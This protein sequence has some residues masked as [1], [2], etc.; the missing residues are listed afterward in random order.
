MMYLLSH[1]D[2]LTSPRRF[3]CFQAPPCFGGVFC[4]PV[5]CE[6]ISWGPGVVGCGRLRCDRV[7]CLALRCVPLRSTAYPPLPSPHDITYTSPSHIHAAHTH[8]TTTTPPHTRHAAPLLPPPTVPT[9]CRHR[10][11]NAM[12]HGVPVVSSA[13]P[14]VSSVV[15]SGSSGAVPSTVRSSS[16]S[17]SLPA[18]CIVCFGLPN[19]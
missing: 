18:D 8:A 10:A 17:E 5:G 2:R 16:A 3:V 7:W 6:K 14:V 11:G 4:C 15:S 1:T 12:R 9:P 13:V 19:E